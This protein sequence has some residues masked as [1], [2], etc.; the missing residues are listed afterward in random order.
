M[1]THP[2]A[3]DGSQ[4]CLPS[5]PTN[6]SL[7]IVIK[8]L[9][10]SSLKPFLGNYWLGKFSPPPLYFSKGWYRLRF[11]WIER[12]N[13]ES[14]NPRYLMLRRNYTEVWRS[15]QTAW[16]R[17]WNVAMLQKNCGSCCFQICSQGELVAGRCWAQ[18]KLLISLALLRKWWVSFRRRTTYV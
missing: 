3:S 17:K 16:E 11:S 1:S 4:K 7:P 10:H 2:P 14:D 6:D 18:K 12:L 9:L 8:P 5:G 13:S 15:I